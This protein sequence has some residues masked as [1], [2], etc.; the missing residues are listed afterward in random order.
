[1]EPFIVALLGEPRITQGGRPC[2][3][4]YRQ[5][6][7]VFYY[8]LIHKTVNRQTLSALI[9][10]EECTEK[11]L[12]SNLRNALYV[13]RKVFG[14]EVICKSGGELLELSPD[15]SFQLDV[16]RF[17]QDGSDLSLYRG[18]FLDGFYLKNNQAFNQWVDSSRQ[19][20]RNLY[21]QRLH[22]AISTA[23]D[24]GEDLRC[25]ELC[26][27]QIEINEF[28]ETAYQYLMQVCLRRGCYGEALQVYHRLEALLESELFEQ[29][30]AETRSLAQAIEQ[31]RNQSM[32]QTLTQ[33]WS[34]R[35]R[36][37]ASPVFY[38]RGQELTRLR[39]AVSDLV[40]GRQQGHF[41][42]SGEPGIGKTELVYQALKD[43]GLPDGLLI[44][45]SICYYAEEQYILKPWQ[46][47]AQ[48]LLQFLQ[49]QALAE[50]Y[51]D[52]SQSLRS[53][54]PFSHPTSDSTLEPDDIS[55]LDYKSIQS[56]FVHGLVRL[57]QR[58][59][60]LLF[61]D[62]LQWA[63]EVS[64][65][66]IR[67]LMTTMKG[68]E[69]QT[70]LF[71]FTVR[72]GSEG[73]ARR[74]LEDMEAQRLLQSIS[75]ARFDFE[76]TTRLA[77]LM[78]PDYPFTRQTQ[79]LIF[80]ETEG[81][82][83]FIRE[84]ANN[85]KYSGSPTDITPGMRNILRQRVA[86][87]S[88][89]ARQI[90]DLV[91][92]FFDGVS[93]HCLL[94]LSRK[95][96]YALAELLETLL[97][98]DL[99]KEDPQE[100][101]IFFTFTHQKLMEYVYDE[102]SQIKRRILHDKAGA[103]YEGEL[104]QSTRDMALYP[105]L[106]YHFDRGGNQR[107]YLK[108]AVKYLYHYLNVTHEFFPVMEKNLRLI[109]LDLQPETTERL[110]ADLD[111]TEALLSALEDKLNVSGQAILAAGEP[112]R[113]SLE[114]LSDYLHMIGRRYIRTCD[115]ETGLRYILRLKE[116]NRQYPSPI[117]TEKLLQANRQLMCIYVNRYQPDKMDQVI[118]ES[119]Q[120]LQSTQL[121]DE[122][123]I[124]LRLKGLSCIMGGHL[125]QGIQYLQTAIDQFTRSDPDS[126]R[127][128]LAAAYSWVGEAYRQSFQFDRA[129]EFHQKAIR[130]GASNFLVGGAA[131]LYAYAGMA[132]YDGGQRA[133]AEE[134]LSASRRRYESG[135]LMWGRSLPYSYSALLR[136]EE[137]RAEEASALLDEALGYAVRL[138]NPFEQAVVH[139]IRAQL[140]SG[141]FPGAPAQP[142][143]AAADLRA[144]RALLAGVCSPLDQRLLDQLT[145]AAEPTC[146]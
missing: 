108:Y 137:G 95:E 44:L 145:P 84:A 54:F 53:M 125:P 101:D 144:A 11:K 23:F 32:V 25:E 89:E 135:S 136:L 4:P 52:L 104:T 141:A 34:T 56:T 93:Y 58:Q 33:K 70:I 26:R 128:N 24:A 99:L 112:D 98:Q 68:R 38:G 7:A 63:D 85:I 67:D 123:A 83:L 115:Y 66:L 55:T 91:S 69:R 2:L 50:P 22:G 20:Y 9:W 126:L 57:S 140:H 109:S 49:R 88:Q 37:P 17:V 21:L 131:V 92:I 40:S 30:Q 124:W 28:D 127:Y 106:I 130:T 13:I 100:T 113:E 117:A 75:L 77:S 61:F 6:E 118:C 39:N 122:T 138:E 120:L 42:V 64:L 146:T 94:A 59:P 80:R 31:Q 81:N 78:V 19:H 62:D 87:L 107:K 72:S 132:A 143:A 121:S 97:R 102:M 129:L 116:L 79:E 96:D 133:L 36:D 105:K 27:K 73:N 51:G 114:I 48:R 60:I 111:H 8:L 41:A 16:D 86:P 103:Y 10:E 71:L 76:D 82:A 14:R 12:N 65:S 43:D 47:P 46:R 134:Y 3:L 90:L 18:D 29:P 110:S 5:A 142:E 119:L 45:S 139:R 15:Y 35:E 74:F 1:M